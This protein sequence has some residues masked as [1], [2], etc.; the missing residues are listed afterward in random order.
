MTDMAPFTGLA[1]V[2]MSS[3]NCLR[4]IAP[5]AAAT[6]MA[7]VVSHFNLQLPIPSTT[8]S[9]YSRL[10]ADISIV[11]TIHSRCQEQ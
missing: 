4:K 7:Y 5:P 6:L 9:L 1:Y 10:F 3:N 2:G 11:N 8:R